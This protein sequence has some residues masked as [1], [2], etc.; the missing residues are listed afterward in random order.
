VWLTSNTREE[1][2]KTL[3][4]DPLETIWKNCIFRLCGVKNFYRR[5]FNI[6]VTSTTNQRQQWL[7]EVKLTIDQHFK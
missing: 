1:R 6:V 5:M 4:L 3:F 7:E 2:E